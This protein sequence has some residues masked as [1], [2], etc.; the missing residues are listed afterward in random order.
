MDLN[1][2]RELVQTVGAI[3]ALLVGAI[4]GSIEIARF[5]RER[6]HAKAELRYWR[7]DEGIDGRIVARL[8][9]GPRR[10][11]LV[12]AWIFVGDYGTDGRPGGESTPQW[13]EAGQSLEIARP[14]S[15]LLF[16]AD[17]AYEHFSGK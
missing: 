10:F 8:W 14:L 11:Y 6:R 2:L 17:S 12:H 4:T 3:V 13:L 16:D 1:L 9:V 5:R 15:R 7:D